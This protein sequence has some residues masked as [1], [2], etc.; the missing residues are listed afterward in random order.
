[1]VIRQSIIQGLLLRSLQ[2]SASPTT[3]HDLNDLARLGRRA[4]GHSRYEAAN[5]SM[6]TSRLLMG[7]QDDDDLNEF[8]P[9]DLTF[10]TS[11][12]AIGD[13][14]SAGIG[15]GNRLGSVLDIFNPDSGT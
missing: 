10:I 14:Y 13:S 7:R 3:F 15:A 12:A 9:S 5:A 1:M 8:D 4:S 6:T 2:I 11:L